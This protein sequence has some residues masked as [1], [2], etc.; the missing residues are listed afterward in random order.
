[1]ATYVIST[2]L[3]DGSDDPGQSGRVMCTTCVCWIPNTT[4]YKAA[5]DAWHDL[6]AVTAVGAYGT[7]TNPASMPISGTTDVVVP[8]SR[9]MPTTTYAAAAEIVS[10]T[11]T[12]LSGARVQG[13]VSRDTSSVTVRVQNTGL[14]ALST[15]AFTVAVLAR[16][17]LG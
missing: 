3:P 16:G 11:G 6:I 4:A 2:P 15:G 12:A 1:M 13:I 17:P 8:L 9:T 5:H 14:A 7:A 10:G